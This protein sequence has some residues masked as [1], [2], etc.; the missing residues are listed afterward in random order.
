MEYDDGDRSLPRPRGVRQQPRAARASCARSRIRRD[1]TLVGRTALDRPAAR[2]ARPGQP[3]SSTRTCEH[4]VPR[5]LALGARRPDA[6]GR[7][8]WWA[9]WSIRRRTTGDVLR[10]TWSSCCETF[11]SQ[12]ALAILNARAV[13]RAGDARPR[14]LR[15]R[16]P[17]QV[18]VPGQHVPR[19]ADPLN[20]VIGFSEVLLERMF[21]ELNERQEEYLHDILELRP[22][23]ARAAQRDPRPVEGRGRPDGARADDVLG[24]GR[25]RVR[26]LTGPRTR[27]RNHGIT[28]D[29]RRRCRRRSRSKPT[30]CGSSRW[31]S[32]W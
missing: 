20:A 25:P 10:R 26:P 29:A 24:P 1:S 5:R 30:S 28:L 12:S 6:A 11:A 14:E 32:T 22:A 8:R 17:A 3:S 15:G 7:A 4:P 9:S 23:P 2:G 13:P 27:V 16:Q 31:S 21:G 18:R 19:A